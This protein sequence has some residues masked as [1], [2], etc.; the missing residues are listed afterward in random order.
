MRDLKH[1]N[2]D[3][4][5]QRELLTQR[6]DELHGREEHK[7]ATLA[8]ENRQ[9]RKQSEAVAKQRD[10]AFAE[11]QTLNELRKNRAVEG[12]EVGE[13][14]S[15]VYQNLLHRISRTQ[16]NEAKSVL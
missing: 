5:T 4:L 14:K 7:L 1:S 8:F 10:A 12:D 13:L 15:M 16:S 6:I 11:I 9:L 3:L 2:E